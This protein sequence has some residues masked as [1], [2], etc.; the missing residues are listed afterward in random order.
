MHDTDAA[1]LRAAGVNVTMTSPAACDV[2]MD[3]AVQSADEVDHRL[4][5]A[6]FE[7]REVA[8]ANQI[9]EVRA[10]GRTQSLVLRPNQTSRQAPDARYRIAYRAELGDGR[11]F[12]CPLW[13]P[14]IPADGV[15]RAVSLKVDLPPGTQPSD[16]MPALTW[17]GTHGETTLGHLPA[18]VH[19]PFAPPGAARPW[20]M[21]QTMDAVALA[22]ILGASAIWAWWR[23]R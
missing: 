14:T 18:F 4:D 20:S 21:S 12:R 23:K 1:V 8:G 7:L 13:L 9:G 16:A 17:A 2:V 15:S 6:R 11:E 22:V 5:A 19:V 10:I 3:L